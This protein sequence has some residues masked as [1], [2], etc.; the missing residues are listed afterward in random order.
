MP[1]SLVV[2]AAAIGGFFVLFSCSGT[3]N[4][5]QN[6]TE[7]PKVAA[8]EYPSWYG[9]QSVVNNDSLMLGYATAI[10]DD[11]ASSVSKAVSWAESEIKTSLSDKL[12]NIRSE[13]NIEYGT[14]LGL[15]SSRFLIALRKAGNA[16]S[17]LAETGQTEVKTVEGYNSYRSFAEVVVSKKDLID[18]IG[19]RLAGYEKQWNAM[20][21]SKAF[22]NF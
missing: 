15:D 1:R 16:V 7:S 20:K 10:S 13:A 17:Y 8:N 14:E 11:S 12:E 22:E 18:R 4:M 21:E 19:K 3:E 6:S 9:S 2:L 5:S